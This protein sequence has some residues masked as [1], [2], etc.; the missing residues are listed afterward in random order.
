MG[1]GEKH[2][3]L[4]QCVAIIYDHLQESPESEL[5]WKEGCVGGV[6]TGAENTYS[7]ADPQWG[8]KGWD[9][10]KKIYFASH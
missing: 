1:G 4:P 9:G 2:E 3:K 6:E 7:Q 5:S 10:K 8:S